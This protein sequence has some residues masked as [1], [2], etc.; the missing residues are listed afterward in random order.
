MSRLKDFCVSE[1][2]ALQVTSVGLEMHP[3]LPK[4]VMYDLAWNYVDYEGREAVMDVDS[5]ENEPN[6]NTANDSTSKKWFGIF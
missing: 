1:A 5:P 6:T 2:E 3:L 4:P